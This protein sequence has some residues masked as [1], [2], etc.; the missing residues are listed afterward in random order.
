MERERE[1]HW[2]CSA[3]LKGSLESTGQKLRCI[4]K[5][6]IHLGTAQLG[7]RG[8]PEPACHT[9]EREQEETHPAVQ[10]GVRRGKINPFLTPAAAQI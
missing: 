9:L 10:H 6:Q 5:A 2:I 1:L 3:D 7:Y 4:Q 8:F